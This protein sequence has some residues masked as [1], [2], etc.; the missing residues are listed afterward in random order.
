M[1][2]SQFEGEDSVKYDEGE[3]GR[4]EGTG[5]GNENQ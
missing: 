2:K 1:V 5:V 4:T 3:N